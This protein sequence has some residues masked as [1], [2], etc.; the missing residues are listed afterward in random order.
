MRNKTIFYFHISN[1]TMSRK[2]HLLDIPCSDHVIKA[3]PAE[4][5]NKHGDCVNYVIT[6]LEL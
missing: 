1:Y 6:D 4:N 3:G 2:K 5:V